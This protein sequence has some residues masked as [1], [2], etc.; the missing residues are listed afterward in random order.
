[1]FSMLKRLGRLG[2]R[3]D[4]YPSLK[5]KL[6]DHPLAKGEPLLAIGRWAGHLLGPIMG[7]E[8]SSPS[9][10]TSLMCGF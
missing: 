1:M 5:N 4:L 8:Y 3:L 9:N 2:T 6:H 7:L 10:A